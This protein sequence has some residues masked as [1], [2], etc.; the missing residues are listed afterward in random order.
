[1]NSFIVTMAQT[2][3][4]PIGEVA[5]LPSVAALF[6][7]VILT[8]L[9]IIFLVYIILRLLKRRQFI[10]QN[11]KQWIKI[12]DYQPLGA[13]QG[14]YLTEL[15]DQTCIIAVTDQHIQILKEIDVGTEK[16][17]EIKNSLLEDDFLPKGIARFFPH[18]ES[19][20]QKKTFNETD[21]RKQLSEQIRRTERLTRDALRGRQENE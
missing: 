6:F 18:T 4:L 20:S 9:F 12:F 11:Q 17:N 3:E 16:W 10:Q 7:R 1:M 8:L 5:A 2:D 19:S 14:L 13:N 15:Y 21:F